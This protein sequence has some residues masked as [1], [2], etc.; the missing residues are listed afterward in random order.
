MTLRN[1]PGEPI[2]TR[3]IG[4]HF[5]CLEC[6]KEYRRCKCRVYVS[7]DTLRWQKQVVL[8][9]DGGNHEVP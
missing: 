9:R 5:Y 4:A 2:V 1:K 3:E 7:A 8:D 6:G